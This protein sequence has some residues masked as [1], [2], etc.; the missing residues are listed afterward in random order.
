MN[1]GIYSKFPAILME[2]IFDSLKCTEDLTNF[3]V[4]NKSNMLKSDKFTFVLYCDIAIL[5]H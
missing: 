4:D 1:L 2:D 3:L 5:T